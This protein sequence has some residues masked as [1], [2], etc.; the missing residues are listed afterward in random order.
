MPNFHLTDEQTTALTT[1]VLGLV[2]PAVITIPQTYL[3]VERSQG[4]PV[5]IPVTKGN[6]GAIP[7]SAYKKVAFKQ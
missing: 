2:D 6:I 7:D 4:R 1:W 3:P 5:P